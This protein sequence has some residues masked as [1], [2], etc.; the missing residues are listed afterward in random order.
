MRVNVLTVPFDAQGPCATCVRVLHVRFNTMLKQG[1]DHRLI[2]MGPVARMRV[3]R[4]PI[5]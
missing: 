3:A 5:C 1:F 2:F 4:E